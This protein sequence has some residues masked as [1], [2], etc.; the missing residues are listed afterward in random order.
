MKKIITPAVA[1]VSESICDVTGKPAVAKL[2]MWFGYGSPRDGEVLEVDLSKEA[3]EDILQMLQ[4]RHPQF[5]TEDRLESMMVGHR[6]P[7]GPL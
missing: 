5:K 3:G 1:E 6:C 4:A 2:V 7:H